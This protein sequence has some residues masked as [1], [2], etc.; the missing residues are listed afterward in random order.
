MS[1]TFWTRVRRHWR[2]NSLSQVSTLL[3]AQ[4]N[5][6]GPDRPRTWFRSEVSLNRAM[7]LKKPWRGTHQLGNSRLTDR[8]RR[9]N[10]VTAL[11]HGGGDA[12]PALR[13]NLRDDPKRER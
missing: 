6:I 3:G 11:H 10:A 5:R 7:L 12:Y 13:H 8:R 2:A 1:A 4:L 9:L